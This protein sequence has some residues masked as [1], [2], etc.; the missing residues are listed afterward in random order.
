MCCGRCGADDPADARHRPRSRRGLPASTPRMLPDRL[1]VVHLGLGDD[2]HTASWP[3]GDPVSTPQ[4]MVAM[5]GE[6]KGRVRMTLT[7]HAVNAARR[8]LVLATGSREGRH[9]R[10][11]AAAR[12]RPAGRIGSV[13]PAPWSCSTPTPQHDCRTRL[14]SVWRRWTSRRHPRGRRCSRPHVR[15]TCARCSP[16]IRGGRCATGAGRR[17][18]DRLLEEPDR[19]RRRAPLAGGGGRRRGRGSS[20]GDVRRRAHQRHR[21]ACR[22][23]HRAACAPRTRS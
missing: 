4:A 8:R 5:S 13:A 14:A 18:V 3:P 19:R 17:P 21:A 10:T 9:H 6:Y 1:D 12:P 20:R 11:V 2:G 23:A 7:V 15:R 22:A 16:T